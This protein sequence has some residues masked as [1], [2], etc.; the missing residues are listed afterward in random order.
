MK[1]CSNRYFAFWR[2]Q[3][4][5]RNRIHVFRCS[6]MMSDFSRIFILTSAQ[7]S[8]I[9]TQWAEAVH[10]E[11]VPFPIQLERLKRYSFNYQRITCTRWLKS[12]LMSPEITR[13]I[14]IITPMTSS[15]CGA[16]NRSISWL[17]TLLMVL[18]FT[19]GQ[20]FGGHI[21]CKLSESCIAEDSNCETS[22][23]WKFII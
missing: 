13:R 7:V 2:K 22:V 3:S 15:D 6:V 11:C 12:H 1:R 9:Y 10:H 8:S 18:A 23:V 4:G 21:S 16:I 14:I 20:G 5:L 19:I 17:S